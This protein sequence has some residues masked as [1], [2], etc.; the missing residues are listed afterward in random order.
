[1]LFEQHKLWFIVV[2][3]G[4]YIVSTSISLPGATLLTITGGALFGSILG[5]LI[6]VLSATAGATLAFL[7][8]R[9]IFREALESKYRQ[10][11]QEFNRGVEENGIHYVLFLRLMPLFPFFLINIGLGLTRL[12]LNTY[13]LASFIGMIPGTC[14]YTNAGQQL[15]KITT[16]TDILSAKLLFSFG[17]LGVFAL[18]PV[19]F[20][21][22]RSKKRRLYDKI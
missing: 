20:K 12:P 1:M 4:L 5:T 19:G 13:V 6:V 14:V 16:I 15:S 7:M 2:F 10:Q 3:V 9:F 11:L 22:I 21:K 8:S 18:I 17:L